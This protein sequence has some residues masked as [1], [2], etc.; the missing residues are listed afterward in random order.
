MKE[1]TNLKESFFDRI[2]KNYT[3]IVLGLGL[4][5]QLLYNTASMD[6]PIVE[7]LYEPKMWVSIV[8]NLFLHYMMIDA[9]IDKSIDDSVVSQEFEKANA[10]NDIIITDIRNNMD[11]FIPFIRKFNSNEKRIAQEMF[12]MNKGVITVDELTEEQLKDFEKIDYNKHDISNYTLPLLYSK[13]KNKTISYDANFDEKEFKRKG[14]A[15]KAIAIIVLSTLNVG[16]TFYWNNFGDALINTSMTL[17]ALGLSYIFNYSKPKIQLRMRIP[18][19][20]KIKQSLYKSFK[21][22]Q[23][24]MVVLKE[25]LVIE[26]ENNDDE[27]TENDNQ[28]PIENNIIIN[29]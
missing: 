1:K 19:Q 11:Q 22:Y 8:F 16:V 12:L 14:K 26:K 13:N 7:L 5:V 25:E 29:D 6:T 17:G 4:T 18:E 24:G 21:E 10:I 20:V 28:L 9:A 3:W 2:I 27:I 15:S 23:K